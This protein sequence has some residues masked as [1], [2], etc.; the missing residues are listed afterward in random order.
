MQEDAPPKGPPLESGPEY[1]APPGQTG[2][3]NIMDKAETCT[4][5]LL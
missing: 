2:Q 1:N 4:I 5:K 3:G